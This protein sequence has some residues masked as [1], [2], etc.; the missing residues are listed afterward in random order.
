MYP[1]KETK[2]SGKSSQDQVNDSEK[3]GWMRRINPNLMA[4]TEKSRYQSLPPRGANQQG[5]NVHTWK[6]GN[7]RIKSVLEEKAESHISRNSY[8][9]FQTNA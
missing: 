1:I 3:A 8:A 2:G 6:K 4:R 9:R 5:S 7:R